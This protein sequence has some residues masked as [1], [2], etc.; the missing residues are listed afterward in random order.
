M[1]K[2][3]PL[4][5]IS[6]AALVE[7]GAVLPAVVAQTRE[8]FTFQ[9]TT[10]HA[11]NLSPLTTSCNHVLSGSV[12]HGYTR[13]LGIYKTTQTS[14]T[15]GVGGIAFSMHSLPGTWNFGT[16]AG[17]PLF[18]DQEQWLVTK[19]HIVSPNSSTFSWV[20]NGVVKGGHYI[21]GTTSTSSNAAYFFARGSYSKTPHETSGT[22]SYHEW[23]YSNDASIPYYQASQKLAMEMN[24]SKP[25]S[26][27]S[28]S[29]S[30]T[31]SPHSGRGHTPIRRTG[32]IRHRNHGPYFAIVAGTETTCADTT[33]HENNWFD[34]SS[35]SPQ[36][37]L[38]DVSQKVYDTGTHTWTWRANWLPAQNNTLF[39]YYCPQFNGTSVDSNSYCKEE[40]PTTPNTLLWSDTYSGSDLIKIG[41]GQKS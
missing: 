23:D 41:S 31:I 17:T 8:A 30:L 20:E 1:A 34:G 39:Q 26:N 14:L 4:K 28:F 3:N 12:S 21:K 35:S 22:G 6:A 2:R 11:A 32:V 10:G 37:N 18:V 9:G 25:S 5:T 40:E 7:L 15:R 24:K 27:S 36:P 19:L 29:T 38:M 16:H 13:T 33:H